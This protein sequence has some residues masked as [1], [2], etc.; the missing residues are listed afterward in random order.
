MLGAAGAGLLAVF[1]NI[2]RRTL[3][4]NALEENQQINGQ[5]AGQRTRCKSKLG[6]M[7]A[8]GWAKGWTELLGLLPCHRQVSA[9]AVRQLVIW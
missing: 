3:W 9:A 2:K 5:R 6:E 1:D 4:K 7:P 8:D